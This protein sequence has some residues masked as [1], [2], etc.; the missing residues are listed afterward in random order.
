VL[1]YLAKPGARPDRVSM[2]GL[3]EGHLRLKT[4]SC[5]H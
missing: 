3:R 1:V 4:P 5:S 2:A